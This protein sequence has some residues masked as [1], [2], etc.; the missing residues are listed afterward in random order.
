[1]ANVLAPFGFMP[2]ARKDGAAWTGNQTVRK[3]KSN[4]SNKFFKGDVV[5]L[6]AAQGYIDIDAAGNTSAFAGVFIGCRYI[7]TAFGRP[8]WSPFFPG[9][10]TTQDVEAYIIDDPNVIFLV[11]TAGTSGNP[12]ALAGIDLNYDINTTTAGNQLSGLSGMAL[13]DNTGATTSTLPFRVVDVPGIQAP[14]PNIF[15]QSVN[16]YDPTTKFNFVYVVF[17]N[18]NYKSL[19]AA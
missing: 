1:M 3:I 9:G 18:Q 16:G 2:V 8:I 4:N 6:A 5:K 14:L 19:L 10:D 11:Q 12:L 15:G 7:S 17:N 13:D